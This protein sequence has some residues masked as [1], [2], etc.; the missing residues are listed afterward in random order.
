[1][2]ADR[3]PRPSREPADAPARAN[4]RDAS[5]HDPADWLTLQQAACEFN[6]SIST[7]RRRLREGKL[8]NRIVPRRGGF[9]YLIYAPGNRHTS[10]DGLAGC[11]HRDTPGAPSVDNDNGHRT[12]AV[13]SNGHGIPLDYARPAAHHERV[14]Q[15]AEIRRLERQ[16]ENLSHAL[17]RALRVKQVALPPGLGSPTDNPDDPYARYRWLV[18]RRRWWRF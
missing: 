3:S 14:E 11:G 17:S 1:M 10:P 16:V 4:G 9:A 6:V 8:R 15:E 18:R 5:R 2:V 13:S 7:V 12:D